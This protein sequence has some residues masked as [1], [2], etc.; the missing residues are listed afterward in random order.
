M[1]LHEIKVGE[2]YYTRIDGFLTK[3]VVVRETTIRTIRRTY[4]AFVVRRVEETR[5]L[6]KPRR[7]S[8][9][10]WFWRSE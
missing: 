10:Y 9:L 7:A 6:P 8:A 3:V 4:T 5:E 1:K 2:T